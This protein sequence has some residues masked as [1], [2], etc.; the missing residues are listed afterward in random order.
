MRLKNKKLLVVGTGLALLIMCGAYY[1][2]Q[3][4]RPMLVLAD[5]YEV[6]INE[7]F[8]Y[9]SPIEEIKNAR[10][11]EVVYSGEVDTSV[12]GTYEV[13]YTLDDKDY[14][15]DVVVVDTV[16]PDVVLQ[17]Y[18][19]RLG[20]ESFALESFLVSVN[21]ATNTTAALEENYSFSEVGDYMI[22]VVATDEGGNETRAVTTLHVIEPDTEGPVISGL[23]A[24]SSLTNGTVD[25]NSG[26][27]VSDNVDS[28][29]TLTVDSS[30][31]N[32]A[33]AGT[34]AIIYTA[35]DCYGNTTTATR[36]ITVTQPVAASTATTNTTNADGSK[37]V[38]LTFDDGPSSN[39]PKV[40]EILARYNVKAT[41]FV[42]G[43]NTAY[44][45]YIKTA[46]DAGHT[47]GLHTYS[48]NYASVYA[49][50]NAFVSE[51]LQIQAVVKSYIGYD[52]KLF[53]FPGGSSNQVSKQYCTGVVS[54]A[55]SWANQNGYRYFD[56]NV[57]TGDGNVYTSAATQ[58]A[59][60]KSSPLYDNIILLMHDSNAAVNSVEALPSIIEYYLS[61]GY[62]FKAIDSS[63]P[64]CHH[65]IQN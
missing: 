27:S 14:S 20:Q 65:N 46:Y 30:Q 6:E 4:S 64:D 35:V 38:Y 26:V 43:T 44:L 53:R 28:N 37:V 58:I 3:V 12:L 61:Q 36:Q 31:V 17:E 52:V 23:T 11:E 10:E 63:T 33:A 34:Y 32:L 15:C 48:H 39:T 54:S 1:L 60:V 16:S 55:A 24:M 62:T 18:T 47:I 19:I 13:V 2:Y 5:S 57:I 25:Y 9:L 29:P 59:T 45:S 41:F 7:P 56:W 21:D 50:V 42:I 8:D 49:S 22:T 40:L 51:I